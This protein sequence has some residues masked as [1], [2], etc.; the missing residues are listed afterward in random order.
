MNGWE[1]MMKASRLCRVGYMN[2]REKMMKASRLCR[3]GD[4]MCHTCYF[5]LVVGVII[6]VTLPPIVI[7]YDPYCSYVLSRL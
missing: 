5:L 2:G 6:D 7:P 4:L 3:V 1:K